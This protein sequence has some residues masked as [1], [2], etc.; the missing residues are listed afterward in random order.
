MRFN[1]I[2]LIEWYHLNVRFFK[3]K[4]YKGWRRLVF[5]T[6]ARHAAHYDSP[7]S[8]YYEGE[9]L[10]CDFY[11]YSLPDLETLIGSLNEEFLA[12]IHHSVYPEYH[13]SFSPVRL[14]YTPML[15][16]SFHYNEVKTDSSEH[17]VARSI[18]SVTTFADIGDPE[19]FFR[20]IE[21]RRLFDEVKPCKC[22]IADRAEHPDHDNYIYL[23]LTLR[24]MFD[25]RGTTNG[26]PVLGLYFIEDE[27]S[28][29][30]EYENHVYQWNKVLLGIENPFDAFIDLRL[31]N[32]LNKVYVW[33]SPD[34]VE[35][36]KACLAIKYK[37][38]MNIWD[39][40]GVKYS[41]RLE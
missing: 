18:T 19:V 26:L 29:I 37:K 9:G 8:I 12:F 30:V 25:G 21:N 6:A 31:G 14:T 34:Q 35:G 32:S 4:E 11:F 20:T 5:S 10:I 15:V 1:L 27:G 33:L 3:T 7:Q 13:Y 24:S 22:H 40:N 16:M 36:F 2:I 23:S 17:S 41:Y 28:D 39:R 38:T